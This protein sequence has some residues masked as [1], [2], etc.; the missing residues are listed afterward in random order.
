[1]SV[2]NLRRPRAKKPPREAKVWT[3]YRA[4]MDLGTVQYEGDLERTREIALR[5]AVDHILSIGVVTVD[6]V[7]V[8]RKARIEYI[9]EEV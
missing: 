2:T 6:T 1:M 8:K 7:A 4:R 5:K 3:R 9:E